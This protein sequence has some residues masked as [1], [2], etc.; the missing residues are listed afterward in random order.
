MPNTHAKLSCSSAHRWLTCTASPSLEEIYPDQGSVYAQEGTLAHA[1]SEHMLLTALNLPSPHRL[2]ELK[3][4]DLYSEDMLEH[5]QGYAGY[6]LEMAN[7]FEDPMIDVEHQVDLSQ[8]IP[9]GFGTCDAVI[10]DEDTLHIVDLKYGKGIEVDAEDNPQLKLYALGALLE[11]E[12][13]YDISTVLMT[14]YQPRLDAI[15]T[16]RISARELVEWGEEVAQIAKV[17]YD[18]PGEFRPSEKACRFCRAGGH[19]RAR[20]E[21]NL[22]LVRD[23]FRLKPTLEPHEI[24][25]ILGGIK[26][27]ENWIADIEEAAL[28]DALN[29]VEIP[30]FKVVEGRSVRTYTD[31]LGAIQALE[32]AGWDRAVITQTEL[33]GIS[34]LEKVIGKKNFSSILSDYVTKPKGKPKLVPLSDKRAEMN[35]AQEDFKEI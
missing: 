23:E 13:I 19:C 24:A 2:E 12:Q 35:G 22:A 4:S 17:A 33:L 3:E 16:A 11:Y 34:A 25:E 30:G 7:S 26:E 27:W 5:A 14:I 18:G 28:E 31:T 29:G 10:L 6:V 20:A 15:S 32:N 1:L 21:A 9:E 8:V